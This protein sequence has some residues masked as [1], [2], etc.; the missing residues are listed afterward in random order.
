[1][2]SVAE[3]AA[4]R[5]EDSARALAQARAELAAEEAR[6][7]ELH[8]YRRQYDE[9]PG[10]TGPALPFSIAN[11]LAFSAQLDEAVRMQERRVQSLREQL[12]RRIDEW[13]ERR[14]HEQAVGRLAGRYASQEQRE[15]ER[16]EQRVVDDAGLARRGGS[17]TD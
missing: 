8:A 17:P 4:Q 3:L 1:M 13:A 11:R 10:G 7:E 5:A 16:V 12:A 6:L 2:Q 15:S 9:S 14:R